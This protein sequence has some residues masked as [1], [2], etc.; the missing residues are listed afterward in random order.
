MPL[1]FAVAILTTGLQPARAEPPDPTGLGHLFNDSRLQQ[2]G[3]KIFFDKNLSRPKGQSCADCHAPEVGWTGPDGKVNSGYGV[4]PGAVKG[5]FGNRKPTTAAYATWSPPLHLTADGFVGGNFWDGRATGCLLGNP[6]ADQAQGPFLNPLEQNLPN[7]RRVVEKICRGK[8]GQTFR[9]LS[10]DIWK[11]SS[12]CKIGH[13]DLAYAV[14]AWA[15]AAFEHSSKVSPFSSKYDAFLA[16]KARLTDEE[17]RGM[18]LFNGKAQCSKCHP[19]NKDT[20]GQPPQFT[21][22][23]YDNLGIPA[24]P[25]NPFY[26][27]AKKF[28]PLGIKWV[29]PGL[30]GTLE[31]LPQYAMLA[32][33]HRGKHRVPTLRNVDLRPNAEFVKAFGHNGFFKSLEAI[34]HFYNTRDALPDCAR[35]V[36]PAPGQ[37]CWPAPE[38]GKNLNKDELGDLKLTPKEEKALVTFLKTLSDGYSAK[39]GE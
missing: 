5:R 14:V 30:A 15:V 28:N 2:L 11:N 9:A 26:N 29:D 33:E 8:Y 27:V 36:K 37:N 4:Y 35:I 32:A 25:E 17:K 38:V 19:G 6:A 13:T 20:Q 23:T 22:F 16:G 12:I 10:Q 21:D 39:K 34:V 3:E 1:I 7:A 24:N 31:S 18:D